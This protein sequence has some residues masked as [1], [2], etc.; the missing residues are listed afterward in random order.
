MSAQISAEKPATTRVT[1]RFVPGPQLWAFALLG[2]VG[3][4]FGQL[5]LWAGAAYTLALMLVA[6]REARALGATGLPE[7]SRK[8]EARLLVGVANAVV[9][10]LH[11]TSDHHVRVHVRDDA[12]NGFAIDPAQDDLHAELAP[13]ARAE[14]RYDVV[15]GRRGQFAFGAIHLRVRGRFGLGALIVS[16]DAAQ[17][18]RV[19]PNLRAP[20]RYE[21]A[22]RLGALRS[23]GVR[24]VRAP[25]GGGEFEQLREYVAGDSYRDLDWK[26]TAKR[27]RPVTRVLGQE[28]S[29]TVLIALDAGHM[30]AAAANGVT[31]LDHALDAALLLAYVA[32]RNGDKVGLVLFAHEVLDFVPP[33]A[34]HAHYARI[35]EALSTAQAQPTYVDFRRL[36]EFVRARVPRRALLVMFSDL[37]D[38]SQTAPLAACAAA[39]RQRH[40]PLCVSVNDP[41]TEQVALATV[42][43]AQAAFHR[44]AAA[45]ILEDRAA[46]KLHLQRSGVG[47]LEAS[48]AE[49]AV[50]TVNRYLEIK[51]RH[52]L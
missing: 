18:V 40:L 24:S 26:A 32:L 3:Y 49:L 48:A 44:A 50:A 34:G 12:P 14:L 42:T 23:V 29:Q 36:A 25:G 15:P 9:I 19:Y 30:M 1:T 31:K 38:E 39:L 13:H 28:Q 46:T 37:L 41:L 43:D 5:G 21:L 4:P 20:R 47:L 8:V 33:R 51:T 52:A 2:M 17:P 11:N 27:R 45:A 6:L 16:I 10:R 35:L 22:A 7:V